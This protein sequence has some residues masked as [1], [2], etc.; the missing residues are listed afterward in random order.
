METPPFNPETAKS[1]GSEGGKIDAVV[2]HSAEAPEGGTEVQ[3]S[4]FG[5]SP[6]QTAAGFLL[7]VLEAPP[8]SCCC[9]CSVIHTVTD[10]LTPVCAQAEAP[11]S[12]LQ[13]SIPR[14]GAQQRQLVECAPLI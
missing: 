9:C 14:R 4:G 7:P 5:V 8:L 1:D 10:N 2:P 6:H 13:A 3:R 12:Q 11:L